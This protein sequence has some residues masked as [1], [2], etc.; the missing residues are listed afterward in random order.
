MRV[1]CNAVLSAAALTSAADAE[2]SK[3]RPVTKVINLLKDMVKQLEK[4]AE[5]DEEVYNKVACWCQTNDKEKTKSI[6]DAEGRIDRLV[7]KIEEETASSSRLNTEIKNLEVE[8]EKNQKA[9]DQATANRKKELAEFNEDEKDT[10]QSISALKSAVTVLSKHNGGA[11]LLDMQAALRSTMHTHSAKIGDML[12]SKDLKTVQ[13]FLQSPEDYFDAEPTFKQSYAPQ[14]GEIF[15]ILKNMLSTFEADLSQAQKD[16]M[17][18]QKAYEDLKAAKEDEIKQGQDHLEEKQEELASTDEDNAQA[19]EDLED[20]RASLS[21]D[22]AFLANLKEKCQLTDQ[23][24]EQ[25]TSTRQEEISAVSEALSFLTSDEAHDLFSRTFNFVQ[26]SA[27]VESV[28]RQRAAAVLLATGQRLASPQLVELS[29]TVQRDAFVKVKKAIDDMIA[30]LLQD[31]EDEIKQKDFCIEELNTNERETELKNRDKEEAEAKIDTLTNEIETLTN[32][33][34]TLK[35]EIAA[36]QTSLK[37]AGEDREQENKDFQETVADQR[38]TVKLLEKTLDVLKG[39]YN[40]KHKGAS[41]LQRQEPAGPPPPPGFKSYKKN[42]GSGGVMGMIQQIINDAKTEEAE[43][44]QAEKDA[45]AAYESFVKDTNDSITAKNDS[46]VDKSATRADKEGALTD[47]KK[48]LA[49]IMVE[50]EELANENADLH[51]ACDFT[52][53]NFDTRQAARDEEVEGLREAKAALSGAQL[54]LL[55]RK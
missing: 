16:E 47:T 34:D 46:I 55:Q 29:S 15:G 11:A 50:L 51:K 3:N 4:E 18:S 2:D 17:Q 9:L 5:E 13:S 45:Q 30:K 35:A 7:N 19:K 44:I 14:S 38:A 23:E 49:N 27:S 32:E 28:E 48:E 42:S 25:R 1:L 52:L 26:Q 20:T 8:V 31:K 21:A 12:S 41:L 39:F 6:A 43:A 53:K 54:T 37:R 24:Y 36:L 10:L 40:K 22:Q 33:I